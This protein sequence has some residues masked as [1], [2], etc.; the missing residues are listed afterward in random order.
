MRLIGT[1]TLWLITIMVPTD[2]AV[3]QRGANHQKQQ[4]FDQMPMQ[5]PGQP[6]VYQQQP[7]VY[8]QQPQVYQ[9]QQRAGACVTQFGY[10]ATDADPGTSCMCSNGYYTYWGIAQ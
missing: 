4:N 10:C 3:A 5:A 1:C 8:Q 9:Q 2:C 7:Q 6:Q